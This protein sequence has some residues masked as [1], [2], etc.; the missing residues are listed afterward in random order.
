MPMNRECRSFV[1]NCISRMNKFMSYLQHSTYIL[2]MWFVFLVCDSLVRSMSQ[3]SPTSDTYGNAYHPIQSHTHSKKSV[4]SESYIESNKES[5]TSARAKGITAKDRKRFHA[6]DFTGT[7]KESEVVENIAII[8]P[9]IRSTICLQRNLYEEKEQCNRALKNDKNEKL[10]KVSLPDQPITPG[11]QVGNFL[12][13]NYN[14]LILP[15]RMANHLQQNFALTQLLPHYPCN[16]AE[17][18]HSP[19][20]DPNQQKRLLLGNYNTSTKYPENTPLAI[21]PSALGFLSTMPLLFH[22][23]IIRQDTRFKGQSI[24]SECSSQTSSEMELEAT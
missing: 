5:P 17:K 22:P 13:A 1:R 19:R 3:D 16:E 8:S 24:D 15:N 14:P 21:A 20:M 9:T 10:Y 4:P 12:A 23:Q 18:V 6:G 7:R 2:F 11:L